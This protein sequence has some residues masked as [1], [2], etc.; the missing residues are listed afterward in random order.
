M[1]DGESAFSEKN[2]NT[3]GIDDLEAVRNWPSTGRKVSIAERAIRTVRLSFFLNSFILQF[4]E[5]IGRII[6]IKKVHVS[7]WAKYIKRAVDNIN[8][9]KKLSNNLSLFS[10][11]FNDNNPIKYQYLGLP[12]LPFVYQIGD[13]VVLKALATTEGV[14]SKDR[15][16]FKRSLGK[17]LIKQT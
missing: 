10:D 6:F 13:L 4:K 15:P 2:M 14:A 17:L 3:L 9:N 16:G 11:L 1:I 7:N 5:E 12:N 8:E